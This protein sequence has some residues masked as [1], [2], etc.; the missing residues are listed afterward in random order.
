[1][2]Q[3]TFPYITTRFAHEVEEIYMLMFLKSN[4]KCKKEG[5]RSCALGE[6]EQRQR[7]RLS[8]LETILTVLYTIHHILVHI[9]GPCLSSIFATFLFNWS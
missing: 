7:Q 1:M 5:K 3:P 6:R 2:Y 9:A 4:S 8:S